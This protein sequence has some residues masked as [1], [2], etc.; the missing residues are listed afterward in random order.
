MS[1]S[2]ASESKKDHENRKTSGK[3]GAGD[4]GDEDEEEI[5]K[6]PPVESLATL[7]AVNTAPAPVD[8]FMHTPQF[9]IFF[10]EFAHDQT[11]MSICVLSTEWNRM[12]G[13]IAD[14]RII[15]GMMRGE[16]I[17]HGGKDKR[18]PYSTS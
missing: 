1:K 4:E 9:M 14:Q 6:F 10:V 18:R 13:V 3:R 16:L 12:A 5:L 8:D 17:V 11:L 15:E 7:M 2:V